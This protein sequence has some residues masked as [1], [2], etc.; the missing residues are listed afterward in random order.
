MEGFCPQGR[1]VVK[2]SETDFQVR[3]EK[4]NLCSSLLEVIHDILAV[5]IYM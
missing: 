5:D 2:S 3:E 1:A 4:K